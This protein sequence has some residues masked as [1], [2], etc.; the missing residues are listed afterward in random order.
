ML[1]TGFRA[2]LGVLL[3]GMGLL[4][5]NCLMAKVDSLRVQGGINGRLLDAKGNFKDWMPNSCIYIKVRP[6]TQVILPS[7]PRSGNL[8]QESSLDTIN[9]AYRV[10]RINRK[11]FDFSPEAKQEAFLYEL[12]MKSGFELTTPITAL[13]LAVKTVYSI[14]A[15]ELLICLERQLALEV[16][17]ATAKMQPSRVICLDERFVGADADAVKTNGVQIMKSK[18][19]LNFRTV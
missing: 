9:L 19:V 14:A 11:H 5:G 18:A 7:S 8:T 16:L 13:E 12:L 3:L 10:V 1:N 2:V 6:G 17:K 15:G 4:G